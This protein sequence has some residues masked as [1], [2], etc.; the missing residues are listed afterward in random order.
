MAHTP[1][2]I[3]VE[4][5]AAPCPPCDSLLQTCHLAVLRSL[6]FAGKRLITRALRGQ[7]LP[8]P[9]WTRHLYVQVVEVELDRLLDGVWVLVETALPHR[10]G[11]VGVLDDYVRELLLNRQE[12]H[13]DYLRVALTR[14]G[15][16]SS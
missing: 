15:F 6:E 9:E 11:L 16:E 2:T 8:K 4:A 3:A 5:Q 7:L 13:V 14:A 12:H 10:D 1:N